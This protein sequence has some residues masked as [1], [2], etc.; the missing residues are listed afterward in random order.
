MAHE[1]LRY[2][3]FLVVHFILHGIAPLT[4]TLRNP[5]SSTC[6]PWLATNS[7]GIN[8]RGQH[9]LQQSPR[10]STKGTKNSSAPAWPWKV[11][12]PHRLSYGRSVR[13]YFPWPSAIFEQM[14]CCSIVEL[15]GLFD[16]SLIDGESRQTRKNETESND[17]FE[18]RHNK[19]LSWNFATGL[20]KCIRLGMSPFA[21]LTVM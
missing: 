14:H 1:K 3:R 8:R 13:I 11:W 15:K 9:L 2:R 21:S 12:H 20:R 10:K 19:N 16:A 7:Q 6:Q 4:A 5:R 17:G 18:N